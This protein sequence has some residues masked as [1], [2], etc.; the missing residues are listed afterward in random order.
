MTTTTTDELVIERR[1]ELRASPERVRRALTEAD[2]LA[3]WFGQRCE[4]DLRPGGDAWFDWDDGGM[5][6]ARVEVVDAPRRL[7]VRW[8]TERDQGVDDGPSTLMEWRIEPGRD[9]G[10]V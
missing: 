9:G 6:H 3:Q 10:S 1:I 2:E 7:L 4:I 5:Y 8:A